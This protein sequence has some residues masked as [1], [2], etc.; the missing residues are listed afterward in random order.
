MQPSEKFSLLIGDVYD[1]AVKLVAGFS[2]SV[3]G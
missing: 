1:A 2:N 3:V